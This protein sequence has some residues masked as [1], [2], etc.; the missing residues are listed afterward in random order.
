MPASIASVNAADQ[1]KSVAPQWPMIR[2]TAG[3]TVPM[4]GDTTAGPRTWPTALLAAGGFLESLDRVMDGTVR[5]AIALVR[6]PGHH[7]ERRRAM[8]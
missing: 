3:K 6:P 7:A 4:D 2:S 5:S 8:G 1:Q